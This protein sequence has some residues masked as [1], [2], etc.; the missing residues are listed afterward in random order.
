MW[1]RWRRPTKEGIEKQEEDFQEIYENFY[2]KEKFVRV[3]SKGTIPEL[4]KVQNT[5][6]CDISIFKKKNILT[7]HIAIDNLLKGAASQAVQCL[8]LMSGVKEDS[9]LNLL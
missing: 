1:Q 2:E 4:K 3:L 6:F 7:V 9:G 8:N 5:N